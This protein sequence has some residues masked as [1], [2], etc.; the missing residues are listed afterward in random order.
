MKTPPKASAAVTILSLIGGQLL[1]HL[2]AL[3][4]T[5]IGASLLNEFIVHSLNFRHA[6]FLGLLG[7]V[8]IALSGVLTGGL[9]GRQAPL[10]SHVITGAALFLAGL[11]GSKAQMHLAY[12]EFLVA[13]A[14]KLAPTMLIGAVWLKKRYSRADILAAVLALAG[15]TLVLHCGVDQ[16]TEPGMGGDD[17]DEAMYAQQCAVSRFQDGDWLA[18]IACISA[19]LLCDG[20]YAN[21]QEQQMLQWGSSSREVASWGMG[22]ASVLFVAS[23]LFSRGLWNGLQAAAASPT[24]A[25]ALLAYAAGSYGASLTALNAVR[26]LGAAKASFL[27]AVCKAFAVIASLALFPK[28]T[29]I[30]QLLGIAC[31]FAAV[32]VAVLHKSVSQPPPMSPVPTGF[33]TPPASGRIKSRASGPELLDAGSNGEALSSRR[34]LSASQASAVAAR[35]GAT[36]PGKHLFPEHQGSPK[37]TLDVAAAAMGGLTPRIGGPAIADADAGASAREGTREGPQATGLRRTPSAVAALKAAAGSADE[38]W[39]DAA[40]EGTPGPEAQGSAG[41]AEAAGAAHSPTPEPPVLR[42]PPATQ[43]VGDHSP[44]PPPPGLADDE[45]GLPPLPPASRAE[46]VEPPHLRPASIESARSWRQGQ[47]LLMGAPPLP[48][49]SA[50][51]PNPGADEAKAATAKSGTGST[52]GKVPLVFEAVQDSASRLIHRAVASPMVSRA[53]L[54]IATASELALDGVSTATGIERPH[55][56]LHDSLSPL[57]SQPPRPAHWRQL[58]RGVSW[59]LSPPTTDEDAASPPSPRRLEPVDAVGGDDSGSKIPPPR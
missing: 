3:L 35:M 30:W 7:P 52:G 34:R 25:L 36:R 28:A 31:V 56:A 6:T 17:D 33:G 41:A 58:R 4:F 15:L 54:R 50:S 5:Q 9:S 19:A 42:L 12:S 27:L 32:A 18:G 21:T 10:R 51:A 55:K 47:T 37:P 38:A 59:P 11:L 23:S 45:G 46:S 29:T 2:V 44:L 57:A 39:D 20:L 8:G 22:I 26:D 43:R 1:Y 16:H 24:T 53:L 14:S 40:A 13:K 49:R 48:E